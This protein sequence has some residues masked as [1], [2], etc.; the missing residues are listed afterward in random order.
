MTNDP[1]SFEFVAAAGVQSLAAAGPESRASLENP[2]VPLSDPAAWNEAFGAGQQTDVGIAVNKQTAIGISAV[3]QAV[4]MISG[5][6][7]KLPAK[8]YRRLDDGREVDRNHPAYTRIKKFGRANPE[9]SRLKFVRRLMVSALLWE[10][11]WAWI[12][13]S[14]DGRPLALYNL[15]PDRTTFYRRD[16]RN[17]VVSE[18]NGR[19]EAFDP[20]D[21]LHVEGICLDGSQGAD[22]VQAARHDMAL[23]IAAR[24]F[25]SKFFAN[26]AKLDGILQLPP[27]TSDKARRKVEEALAARKSR[28]GAFTSL[29]LREG[30]KWF[31]TSVDPRAATLTEI[32]DQ[33]A[34]HIARFF[35]IPISKLGIKEATSSYNS[36]ESDRQEYFDNCV[37]YWTL[38][39]ESEYNLKLLTEREQ[40]TDSHYIEH[41]VDALLWA[42]SKDRWTIYETAIRSTIMSPNEVRRRENMRPRPG[43]D[44]FNNPGIYVPKD[45]DKPR[46]DDQTDGTRS[47]KPSTRDTFH[48]LAVETLTRVEKRLTVHA[49]K[50]ERQG[51]LAQ[52]LH[53][54]DTAPLYEIWQAT[55]TACLAAGHG[56]PDV[57]PVQR[58]AD[59]LDFGGVHMT[60]EQAADEFF[61]G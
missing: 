5:D 34:R 16:G 33:Q 41:L 37:S 35:N 36:R 17:W 11:G 58:L 44:E 9:L 27:G 54:L 39:L 55:R 2:S 29:V 61:A 49:S 47:G 6:V 60:A 12:Q 15:L 40:Q 43:G 50:A 22:L 42:N 28:D 32:D 56:N 24:G 48:R 8:V 52:F 25:T 46:T 21:V 31:N 19:L 1:I 45:E 53:N 57:D 10:N 4:R 38:A 23:S 26:G 20:A 51:R 30:Y 13:R 3:N 59:S 14:G 18:I 7:S